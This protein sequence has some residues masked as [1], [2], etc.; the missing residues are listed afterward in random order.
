MNPFDPSRTAGGSSGGSAALVG[1]GACDVAL[2]TDTGGSIR[3]PAHY[4]NVVGFKPTYGAL[5]L[6]GVQ[7][8]APSLDHVGLLAKNVEVTQRVFGA[9]TGLPIDSAPPGRFDSASS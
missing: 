2:G 5:P 9:F 7:P 3:I 8:L 4:C 1:A 6:E